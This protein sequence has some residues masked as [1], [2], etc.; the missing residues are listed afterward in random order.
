MVVADT[1]NPTVC[2]HREGLTLQAPAA[3]HAAEAGRMVGPPTGLQDL[4]V[5][6]ELF[7]YTLSRALTQTVVNKTQLTIS[8]MIKDPQ[9]LHT[10][11]AG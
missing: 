8:S 2:V 11:G 4:S 7:F 9:L 3:D 10:S 6:D 1:V 5:Q